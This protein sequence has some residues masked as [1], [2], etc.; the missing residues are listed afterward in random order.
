MVTKMHINE[1]KKWVRKFRDNSDSTVRLVVLPHAGG[2]ANFYRDLVQYL[3]PDIE[4]IIIQYPGRQERLL[5]DMVNNIDDYADRVT[6]VLS[7]IVDGVKPTILYGHS[8][9]ALIAYNML[10]RNGHMLTSI[11]KLV[12]SCH[13]PPTRKV[14]GEYNK[15][16][17]D[18]SVIEYLKSVG[19]LEDRVSENKMMLELII[20]AVRND[21]FAVRNFSLIKAYKVA[22]PIYG[23]QATEDCGIKASDMQKW[24]LL[25]GKEFELVQFP[26]N[27]FYMLD[28]WEKLA[29]YLQHLC[30]SD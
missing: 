2:N 6:E 24:A 13:A 25:T 14:G 20:P 15:V 8:M 26:G 11:E 5:E 21:L 29:N 18:D 9:G 10:N 19:G 1:A 30:N 28:Q 23:I 4:C 16:D 3:R 27:H 7:L 12:V 22:V 17:D